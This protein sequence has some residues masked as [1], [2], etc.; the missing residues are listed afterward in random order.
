MYYWRWLASFSQ[1]RTL[2]IADIAISLILQNGIVI[3][4]VLKAVLE[5]IQSSKF[6]IYTIFDLPFIETIVESE[7][8]STNVYVNQIYQTIQHIF[9]SPISAMLIKQYLQQNNIGAENLSIESLL[10]DLFREVGFK[11]NDSHRLI[12][13]ASIYVMEN[14]ENFEVSEMTLSMMIGKTP[15]YSLPLANWQ[16]I[17]QKRTVVNISTLEIQSTGPAR[18]AS[19][20]SPNKIISI[21]IK[22]LFE[23][24]ENQKLSKEKFRK[25]ITGLI[26]D[27][28]ERSAPAN[29]LGIVTWLQSKLATCKPSSIHTYSNNIT[30]RWLANSHGLDLEVF[31]Q[32]DFEALYGD[33]LSMTSNANAREKSAVLLDS[34]HEHLVHYYHLEP[35]AKM[36]IG[37][38]KSHQKTGY[39]SETMFQAI[40]S[41]CDSLSLPSNDIRN[42]KVGLILG[43]RL[44]MRIGE[45]T[46]LKITEITPYLEFLATRNNR[47]GD[48]KSYAGLRS[49]PLKLSL[50]QQDFD[51]IRQTYDFRKQNKHDLLIAHTNGNSVT[52][53]GFS[54]Q[55]TALIQQVTGLDFLTTHHLRHS[56]ISNLQLMFFLYDKD[57]HHFEHHAL[58]ELKGLLPY[59]DTQAKT[60]VETLLSASAYKK[61]YEIAG[62]AG[63][64]EPS[65]SY[66]SYIHLTDIQMGVMLWQIDYQLNALQRKNMLGLTSSQAKATSH[67]IA[68]NSILYKK[69]GAIYKPLPKLKTATLDKKI[70]QVKIRRYDFN[71]VKILIQSY[72]QQQDFALK[73]QT[74][75]VPQEVFNSWLTNAKQLRFELRFRSRSKNSRFFSPKDNTSLVI[76]KK[77]DDFEKYWISKLTTSYR[78]AYSKENHRENLQFFIQYTLENSLF[79]DYGLKFHEPELLERYLKTLKLLRL[80]SI[81]YLLV[82]NYDKNQKDLTLAWRKAWQGL[83]KQ[84]I[85]VQDNAKLKRKHPMKVTLFIKDE[86]KQNRGLLVY[87]CHYAYILMGHYIK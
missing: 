53:G 54:Q 45:I 69:L 75:N 40:L 63:H 79:D 3:V 35:V 60:I 87:F 4:E 85:I 70:E 19:K 64:S 42:F 26:Q 24:P 81:V 8:F 32:E 78:T 72:L 17:T 68:L 82:E 48:N 49:L 52:K 1:P 5:Q 46:K 20:K 84:Q 74:Y 36:S 83:T 27:L 22:K 23:V 41:A 86:K 7:K 44:G 58:H 80:D 77:L 43:H 34:L 50:P 16:V 13:D 31:E 76:E 47:F 62:F 6:K 55:I 30:D 71:E 9:L 10:G 73:L 2:T 14:H 67:T 29:E 21:K 28:Q 12:L 56:C 33:I 15:T 37:A 65:T 25:A 61:D 39:L 51:F 59:E 38:K 11:E 18:I 66:Q 57:Y